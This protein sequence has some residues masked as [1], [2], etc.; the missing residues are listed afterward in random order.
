M[1]CG[2]ITFSGEEVFDSPENVQGLMAMRRLAMVG[3]LMQLLQAA[4]WMRSHPM[5]LAEVNAL[6]STPMGGRLTGMAGNR[7]GAWKGRT[8]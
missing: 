5:P 7:W 4:N 6:L 3:G 1:W 8:R 2:R